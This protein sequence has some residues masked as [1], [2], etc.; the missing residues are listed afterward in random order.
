[1]AR[2]TVPDS[3]A[4]PVRLTGERLIIEYRPDGLPPH[5]AAASVD[6]HFRVP[7]ESER[8]SRDGDASVEWSP[9]WST[10][11]IR[12]RGR[13]PRQPARPDPG[14][15]LRSASSHA[16]DGGFDD[17]VGPP[18]RRRL[19]RVPRLAGVR[20]VRTRRLARIDWYPFM[21]GEDYALRSLALV[22]G[23]VPLPRRSGAGSWF[24]RH[25]PSHTSAEYREI[26]RDYER[27][28]FPP[29]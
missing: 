2:C 19:G 6:R 3:A 5:A 26:V 20:D 14:S 23:P 16:A 25:W 10:T 9:G 13:I 8:A 28:G 15:T 22:S 1:M 29:T 7:R 27:Y 21:Y 4:E 12:R 11:G 24:S 17:S 18:V